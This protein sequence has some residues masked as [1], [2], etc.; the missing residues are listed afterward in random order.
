MLSYFTIYVNGFQVNNSGTFVLKLI[1]TKNNLRL[2][3]KSWQTFKVIGKLEIRN[4]YKV[5]QGHLSIISGWL[6]VKIT[7]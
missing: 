7:L 6:E 2:F 1:Y 4:V 5:C 3:N